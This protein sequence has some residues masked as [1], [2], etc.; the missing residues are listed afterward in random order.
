M[1]V[2]GGARARAA[3]AA[4]RVTYGTPEE[5]ARFL[6]ALAEAAVSAARSTALPSLLQRLQTTMTASLPHPQLARPPRA[7]RRWSSITYAWRFS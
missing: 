2:R 5:N 4:L 7:R 6:D 3:R 1:L